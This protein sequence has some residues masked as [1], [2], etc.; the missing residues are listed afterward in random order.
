MYFRYFRV[1]LRV[2]PV[3][4]PTLTSEPLAFSRK[5]KYHVACKDEGTGGDY[6]PNRRELGKHDFGD[7]VG[8]KCIKA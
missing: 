2:P 6:K 8:I 1:K 4:T 5:W 7:C 3:G